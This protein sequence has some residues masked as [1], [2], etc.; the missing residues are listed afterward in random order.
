MKDLVLLAESFLEKGSV[1]SVKPLGDGFINDTYIVKTVRGDDSYIL[2]RKNHNVFP[3]VPAMMDNIVKV[4]RHIAAKVSAMGLDPLKHSLTVL[5]AHDGRP[6]VEDDGNFWTVALYIKGSVCYD[7]AE[8]P[9]L[10][11]MGGE[12]VG[13]FQALLS[14]FME[15][16]AETLPGFHKIRTRF[17][18]W[19]RTLEENRAG[20]K[21][22]V[23]EEIEWIESRRN[24][25]LA[26]W[27][28]VESGEIPQR[29]A[30]NDTKLANILFDGK[31]E[32]L[33][34]IDLD[35]VMSSTSLNDFGDSIRSY[36]NTGLE[37]DR[38]LENVGV[39]MEMFRAFAEGYLK[40]Q[41][42]NLTKAEL[43]SLAFSA[44]YITYEQTLRFLMDYIDGDRYYKIKYKEH[45][46][47]RTH[48]QY[49]LL[50]SMEKNACEMEDIVASL[51]K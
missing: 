2:Q 18:Q 45:N 14:D 26:F 47:V 24:E 29:V 32:V 10:A 36:A 13:S 6:Y 19:D 7:R 4:S 37:D 22:E 21:D 28:K 31:G 33:C 8:T 20:R 39:S 46:L 9:R 34:M 5:N 38:C 12:G 48:A 23:R 3:D 16:L 27:E 25:M 40:Y 11:R 41:K 43:D 30:H 17:E 51:S 35:T 49:E 1:E 15:P 42:K 44:R 50:K